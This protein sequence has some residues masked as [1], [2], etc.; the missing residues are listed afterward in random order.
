[1]DRDGCYVSDSIHIGSACSIYVPNAFSPNGD[2]INDYFEFISTHVT[3]AEVSVY[4][5]WGTRIFYST[6]LKEKWD[7]SDGWDTNY[8]AGVY[9]YIIR[10]SY[11]SG[12]TFYLQ[13]HVLLI[14]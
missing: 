1:V 6:A 12:K 14:R 13:G 2:G 10:G 11:R 7:G 5:R 3:D 4:N 8:P 9:V